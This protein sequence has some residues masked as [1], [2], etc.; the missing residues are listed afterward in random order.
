MSECVIRK[1][2]LADKGH[3]LHLIE[4]QLDVF[5]GLYDR[6]AI[7]DA[8]TSSRDIGDLTDGQS[9]VAIDPDDDLVIGYGRLT[10][11]GSS[12]ALTHLFVAGYAQGQGV[13]RRLWEALI[14]GKAACTVVVKSSPVAIKVYKKLG[15]DLS[16]A[17]YPGSPLK[18]LVFSKTN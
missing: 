14:D 8:K 15:F 18:T 2:T 4:G 17:S 16:G 7:E 9:L 13:G 3:I 6:S 10:G 12:Y 5:E 11:G 1:P